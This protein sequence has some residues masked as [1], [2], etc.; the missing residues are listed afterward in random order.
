VH[1]R[2]TAVGAP[3]QS[4]PESLPKSG[5]G[6]PWERYQAIRGPKRGPDVQYTDARHATSHCAKKGPVGRRSMGR[7]AKVVNSF[8][9]HV[10]T[11]IV[12]I[13]A[14]RHPF[15]RD[16]PFLHSLA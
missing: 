8:N 15:S 11:V 13:Q 2:K 10:N 3:L 7:T 16:I 1:K 6:H 9:S 5:R 12:G 4:S 14:Y